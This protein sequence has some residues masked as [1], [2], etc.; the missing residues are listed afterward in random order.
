MVMKHLTK[1]FDSIAKLELGKNENDDIAALGMFAKDGEYVIFDIISECIGPVEIWLNKIQ[2]R[3]R[4]TL[5]LYMKNAVIAYEEKPREHWLFDYP[6]QVC[7]TF[8]INFLKD[9]RI[10]RKFMIDFVQ[11][12]KYFRI[13]KIFLR[14]NIQNFFKS[15]HF[16][17]GFSVWNS[18]MVDN[19]SIT[20]I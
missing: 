7:T 2:L 14:L 16:L 6:A 4:S 20:L 5:R 8:D 18:N 1:L 13:L 9:L 11:F 12:E 19:R 10:F 3:M 17:L 15:F